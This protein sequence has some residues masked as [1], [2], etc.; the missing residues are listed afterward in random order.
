MS[1]GTVTDYPNTGKYK[2][3]YSS[4]NGTVAASSGIT[5]G[6]YNVFPYTTKSV[7]AYIGTTQNATGSLVV[8]GSF[9][10]TNYYTLRSGSFSSGSLTWFTIFDAVSQVS[11][12][13]YNQV[14]GS[15][16]SGSIYLAVQS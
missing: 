6:N 14:T 12:N 15:A 1:L 13:L 5:S 7:Y 8:S 3:L 10:G 4:V 2:L 9:D 11:V 16:I